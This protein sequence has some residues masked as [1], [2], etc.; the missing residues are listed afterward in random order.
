MNR[1]EHMK[2][3][4]GTD[5]ALDFNGHTTFAD[6]VRHAQRGYQ[7]IKNGEKPSEEEKDCMLGMKKAWEQMEYL[8]PE[9]K[10]ENAKS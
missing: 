8:F 2:I 9:L 10:E 4:K 7:K 1:E 5:A 3:R 6:I